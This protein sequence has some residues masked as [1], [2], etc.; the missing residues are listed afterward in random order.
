VVDCHFLD[1]VGLLGLLPQL[2]EGTSG[3]EGEVVVPAWGR[4]YLTLLLMALRAGSL[5]VSVIPLSNMETL[6]LR[7]SMVLARRWRRRDCVGEG[8]RDS[9][10]PSK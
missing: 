7:L 3:G 4:E 6:L 2:V 1:V 10:L 5:K 8:L 9:K